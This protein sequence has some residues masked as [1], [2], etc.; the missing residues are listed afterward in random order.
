MRRPTMLIVLATVVGL[1]LTACGKSTPSTSSS[2]GGGGITPASS[3]TGAGSTF[4]APLYQQWGSTYQSIAHVSVSYN[5]VGSSAGITD[6]VDKTVDFG[7]SD[8]SYTPT[9]TAAAT[10]LNIPTAI[11]AVVLTYNLPT[12][13]KGTTLNFSPATVVNIFDGTDSKWNSADIVADNPGVSLPN[14]G[15]TV[16]HRSDGSGTTNIFTS[17]LALVSPTWKSKYG[18]GTTVAWPTQELGG[19]GS[20]GVE[21]DVSSTPGAIGYVELTYAIQNKTPAAGVK[22]ADG[23][24]FVTPTVASV[25]AATNQV[26]ATAVPSG[27]N[28]IFTMLNE[29]GS[30]SYP[31]AGPTYLLVYQQQ[32]NG[33]VG[34]ALV[35]FM[36]WGLT[37]GQTL[38]GALDYVTL[39]TAIQQRA[40][41]ATAS[42]TYNGTVLA[43]PTP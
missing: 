39:P 14:T 11:S 21:A 7:A 35:N 6:I 1:L 24:A 34:K 28:I 16:V 9:E 25:Q 20:A 43:S 42:I 18:S 32:T 31:I 19:K 10:I 12:L 26:Q 30:G 15:I 29:P 22:N 37:T 40:L 13:A 5:A 23:T 33:P 8:A 2:G 27:D 17:W 4:A 41:A 3:L 38:E 36:D